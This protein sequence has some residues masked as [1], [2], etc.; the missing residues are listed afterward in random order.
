[1]SESQAPQ[2]RRSPETYEQALLLA[3][4]FVNEFKSAGIGD[5]IWEQLRTTGII[6]STD[7]SGA[8]TVELAMAMIHQGLLESASDSCASSL[9]DPWCIY[10]RACDIDAICRYVLQQHPET[11][12]PKHIMGDILDRCNLTKLM[13][14]CLHQAEEKFQIAVAAE[15]VGSNAGKSRNTLLKEHGRRYAEECW[16]ALLRKSCK[17]QLYCQVCDGHCDVHPSESDRAGRR[18]LIAGGNTCISWST[19]GQRMGWLHLATA[20][21]L[22]WLRDLLN[23]RPEDNEN[24][25]TIP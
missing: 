16:A 2:R 4:G 12:R 10:W 21:F 18:Y 23:A 25:P 9:A 5:Q 11:S 14:Q 15:A 17:G 7:Y 13:T 20:V 6:L 24:I 3:P 8:G 22:V 1:M 19:L